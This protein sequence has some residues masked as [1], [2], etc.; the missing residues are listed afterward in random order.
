MRWEVIHGDCL[1][2]LAT[3]PGSAVIVTD[4]PYGVS[5][6]TA[7][8]S[9]GRGTIA[10]SN[11]YPPVHG[12]DRPFDPS[13]WISFAVVVLFGANY[14]ADRLPARGTWYVWDKR[15]AGTSDDG[16]DCELAWVKG[17]SGTVPRLFHHKW[18][19]MIRASKDVPRC[20]PTQKPVALMRWVIENL[21]L[22]PNSLIVD[23]FCGSGSTGVAAIAEGH[24][25]IGIER[26]AA[27]VE[28][29]RR[30]IAG[31]HHTPSLFHTP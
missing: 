17:V 19:G 7:Y 14:F 12:D 20:H 26:E 5:L 2:A 4:P 9:A 22:P 27:Y 10:G 3:L 8:K 13:P 24:R 30:R 18:R 16:A 23:P 28:I 1:D 25:F 11:D 21:D 15:E 31:A 6:N 29:A